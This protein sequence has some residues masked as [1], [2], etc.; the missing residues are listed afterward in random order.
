MKRTIVVFLAVCILMIAMI[1]SADETV[2]IGF[3]ADLFSVAVGQSINLKSTITP[4][5]NLKLEWSSSDEAV[6]T[7]TSKGLVKGVAVG[8]AVI[9][10]KTMDD[11]NIASSCKIAVVLPVK[12][13][14]FQEKS[15][16][17]PPGVSTKLAVHIEPENATNKDLSYSSSNEKVAVI[18]ENGRLFGLSA[19]VAKITVTANDGSKKKATIIVKI[20]D[21]DMVFTSKKPQM[22]HFSYSGTGNVKIRGTVK[23]GN[24]D[25]K[26]VEYD[27]WSDSDKREEIDRDLWTLGGS[28][29]QVE[30]TPLHPGSDEVIIKVNNSKLSFSVF[31]ADDF[32]NYEIQHV[33]VPDT[34]P[35]EKNGAFR[36]IVYGTPYSEVIDYMIEEYGRDYEIEEND[37]GFSIE[38]RNPNIKVAG[39]DVLSLRLWFCYDEDEKG[40]IVK[41][42]ER[43]CFYE[44]SYTI[45]ETSYEQDFFDDYILG[46]NSITEDLYSKITE[47]YGKQGTS[48][49]QSDVSRGLSIRWEDNQVSIALEYENQENK[50]SLTYSWTPGALK[51]SRLQDTV[52]YLQELE[53][54]KS[55]D[56]EKIEYDSS[57]EGL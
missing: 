24:V 6:A 39:H 49:N 31:V 14:S 4:K 15:I 56:V 30:V 37:A 20:R 35:D 41:D 54:Q 44:A 42:A 9:T 2:S 52:Q 26:R 5:K 21:Y 17:L 48:F 33:Y 27:P 55:K 45:S 53:E 3:D 57:D 40:Y 13:I 23:N 29:E 12:K 51:Y 22:T 46:D 7:V 19:G 11:K 32:E 25:I 10:V 36:D 50:I 16:E 34:T 8:E 43:T 47:K 38:F 28:H 1:A 18:D